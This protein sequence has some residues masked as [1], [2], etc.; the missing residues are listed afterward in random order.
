M[1]ANHGQKVR[2]YHEMVGCNSRL[3]AIQAAILG[4]KIKRLD[5]IMTARRRVAAAYNAAFAGNTKITTP[6]VAPG[7]DMCI[8]SIHL[9]WKELTEMH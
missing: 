2:Y 4:V 7:I 8:I 9:N 5:I 3:D 1:I 6:F